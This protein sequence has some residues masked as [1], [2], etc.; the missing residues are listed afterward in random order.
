MFDF[1]RAL[2]KGRGWEALAEAEITEALLLARR[3]LEVGKEDPDAL[4]MAADTNSILAH[5]HAVAASAIERALK[6]NPNSAHAWMARGWV[7]CCLNQPGQA[8]DALTHAVRLSP[9]DPLGYFFRCRLA[10]RLPRRGAI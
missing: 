5:E 8:I 7:A 6:L 9:L 4:W 3:A 10:F 1:C 2:Q